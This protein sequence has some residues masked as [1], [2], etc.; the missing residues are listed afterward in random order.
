M[1]LSINEMIDQTADSIRENIGKLQL[2]KNA[3][4]L[5][6]YDNKKIKEVSQRLTIL[7]AQ[8][9]MLWLVRENE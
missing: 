2:A 8:L 6:Y 9:E 1:T 7:T 4:W 3:P 5:D